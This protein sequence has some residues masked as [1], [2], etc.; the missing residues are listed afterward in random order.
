M[1]LGLNTEWK[2]AFKLRAFSRVSVVYGR[3]FFKKNSG[4]IQLC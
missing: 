3:P 4:M 1:L 2:K